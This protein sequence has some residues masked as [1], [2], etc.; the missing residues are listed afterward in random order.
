MGP[1]KDSK[2][3]VGGQESG[4]SPNS[5]PWVNSIPF[6][7]Y[8]VPTLCQT[9]CW[10]LGPSEIAQMRERERGRDGYRDNHHITGDKCLRGMYKVLWEL[11]APGH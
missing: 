5:L 8:Q 10:V 2:P 3:R 1:R 11:R 9:W 7:V 4:D 6:T